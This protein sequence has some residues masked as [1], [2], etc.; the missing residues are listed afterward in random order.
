MTCE[1]RGGG[2]SKRCFISVFNLHEILP[3]ALLLERNH[4]GLSWIVTIN[5]HRRHRRMTGTG[6]ER[7]TFPPFLLP[8][9]LT[10]NEHEIKCLK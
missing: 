9:M 7:K 4:S 3:N 1:L 5:A 10:D 8:D 2:E 6:S